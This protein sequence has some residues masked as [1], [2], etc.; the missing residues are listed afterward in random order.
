MEHITLPGTDPHYVDSVHRHLQAN[1]IAMIVFASS[2]SLSLWEK[3]VGHSILR[4]FEHPIHRIL[5][6]S[7]QLP[8]SRGRT[9]SANFDQGS[10][11]LCALAA[12][13]EDLKADPSLISRFYPDTAE[14]LAQKDTGEILLT[15]NRDMICGLH[16]SI[17]FSEYR[18]YKGIVALNLR[19][20]V[21]PSG[22]SQLY[23]ELSRF[24]RLAVNAHNGNLRLV[25]IDDLR[26]EQKRSY[27][28]FAEY[29]DHYMAH[30]DYEKWLGMI[31][32][33]CKSFGVKQLSR[34]LEIACGTGNI[35]EILVHKGYEVDACDSSP[36]M[37]HMASQKLFK[38]NLFLRSMT[39]ELP[40]R[41]YDLALCLFDSINYL[42]RKTDIKLLLKHTFATLRP[43]GLFVFD[44]STLMNSTQNFNDATQFTH[45]RDGY[46]VHHA[47]YA[48]LAGKQNSR[49]V[50]FRK[51]GQTYQKHEENHVQRV[52]RNIE[53]IEMI[54]NSP[55]RLLGIFS[56][57]TRANLYHK[58]SGDIDD[59]YA[60]LFYVMRKEL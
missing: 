29:Y 10:K 57:E 20:E 39:E 58:R 49:L 56:P 47:S 53:M 30:V 17:P 45:V 24:A 22:F 26:L 9:F 41:N 21:R 52:Y 4:F 38:P 55:F 16:A 15:T 1:K 48:Y 12:E 60:R 42:P 8:L 31:L 25:E 32:G 50:L 13:A 37:L 35:A 54:I 14:Y 5:D 51:V 43:G 18:F 40:D 36:F 33:W 3:A 28:F 6:V 46:L 27:T 7:N 23:D 44:I 19:M 11:R 59:K 2:A 34:I